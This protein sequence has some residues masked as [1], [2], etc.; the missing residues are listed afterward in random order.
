MSYSERLSDLSQEIYQAV[1]SKVNGMEEGKTVMFFGKQLVV[2][3]EEVSGLI[4][5]LH[6]SEEYQD[7]YYELPF[8]YI[9]DKHGHAEEYKI[10][11]ITKTGETFSLHL[12]HWENSIEYRLVEK[13]D[14]HVELEIMADIADML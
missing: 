4:V 3:N 12:H 6:D 5:R 9:Y 11:G 7:S 10:A 1:Q 8:C 13:G 2:P 14:V